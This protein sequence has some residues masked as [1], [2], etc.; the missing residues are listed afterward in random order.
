VKTKMQKT[1]YK[2]MATAC[3]ILIFIAS[4]LTAISVKN[5]QAQTAPTMKSY[6]I[7]DAIPNPV[8]VG[9]QT[10]IKTGIL[11]AI[12]PNASYGWTGL[13][14]TVVKPDGTTTTLGP[15]RTDST[16][17]TYTTFVPDQVGTYQL[18]T[19]FPNNTVTV[20][21]SDSERPGAPIVAGTVMLASTSETFNL[22]VQQEPV[23]GVSGHALP[24][25]YWSRP[26]DPQLREWYSISGN[27]LQIPNNG[28]ALYN[29]N[30]PE[31]PH[32]LWAKDLTTGGLTGG[33][34]P[35][36]YSG[37]IAPSSETGDAYE[38]KFVGSVVINGILYYNTAA[39]ANSGSF[40]GENDIAAVD[41]HTGKQLWY[42]E[43]MTLSFGQAL[44]F[45]SYNYCG[46]FTYLW[47]ISGTT[48][49]AYDPFNGQWQYSMIN[50]PSGTRYFG[51]Q[52]EIL[53]LQVDYTRGWM[54]L[55]NSTACAGATGSWGSAATL[56]TLDASL[57]R[58]Y[59][60]N[61][62]IP[63]GL[64]GS[65]LKVYPDRVVGII[66]NQTQVR[67][68][69]LN[70]ADLTGTSKSASLLFDKTWAAPSEWLSG[71]NSLLYAGATNEAAKGVIAVWS[72]EL[73]QF[74]G[75]STETG[76]YLWTTATENYA[77]AYGLGTS[78]HTW[79]FTYGNLYSVG[80]GG[81]LYAYDLATGKTVWTY[82]LTGRPT[83]EPITGNNWWGWINVIADGKI[84]IGTLE[85]SAQMPLPRGAPYIC[86][87]ATDGS[88]IFRVNGMFRETRWGGNGVMGDSIIAAMDTYD[89]RIYGIGQGP[90]AVTVT[91]PDSNVVVGSSITIRGTVNDISAGTKSDAL[92]ARFPNGVPA[93]SDEIQSAWMLYLYKQ[94]ERP[95][96]ASG[97]PVSIDVIDSNGNYRNIGTTTSDSNGVYSFSW[98]PDIPGKYQVFATFAGSKA[99]YP[100]SAETSFSA[101]PTAATPIPTEPVVQ[102]VTDQYFVPAVAGIIVAIAIVGALIVLL[103]FRKRP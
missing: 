39:R 76:A 72:K 23:Q 47:S 78:E 13:T 1:K 56:K 86:L 41:L 82:D 14:V 45:V 36:P 53:I 9:Q 79:Y 27:W 22:T 71:S 52:G 35:D 40:Y 34:Y 50:M 58:C 83:G 44:Y 98:V 26:I 2:K 60:W 3:L 17:S 95:T 37:Q 84:Y 85:H 57:A 49:N 38:G 24:S 70:I 88:E 15:F 19:N 75:F 5:V 62:S 7:I 33:L 21:Y 31:T 28:L 51:P 66:F 30:A 100:S 90:T 68:W 69:G 32:V 77:D 11:Q 18:T 87:N 29:D 81:T 8:G 25:E 96:N 48:Y 101:D 80:V 89:Q 42:K 91:A 12:G 99:Y 94:F 16:G 54:A 64:T 103:L 97:V 43:N 46:V 67:V 20:T 74:Y 63:A 102:S 59:I 55:W 65:T 4:A 61:V 73:R 6:P 92:T 93:V 10:L